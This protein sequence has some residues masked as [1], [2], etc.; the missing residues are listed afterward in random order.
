[1]ALTPELIQAY[2]KALYAVQAGPVLRIG[3]RSA[4]LE[5]LLDAQGVATAAF[6]TAANPRGE[7]RSH[8]AN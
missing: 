1:M 3:E 7:P 5:T 4:A 2:E 8:A 6:V